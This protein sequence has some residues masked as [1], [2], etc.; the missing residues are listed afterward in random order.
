ME[1]ARAWRYQVTRNALVD[2]LRSSRKHVPLS[3]DLA[4]PADATAPQGD[5]LS[6]CLPRVLAELSEADRLA[7]TLCDTEGHPPLEL[8][9]ET[10]E[11]ACTEAQFPGD[12]RVWLPKRRVVFSGNLVYVDRLLGVLSASGV[13]NGQTASPWMRCNPNAWSQTTAASATWPT[14]NGRLATTTA[15]SPKRSA[16]RRKRRS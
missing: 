12:A 9:G 14:R 11:V 2:W 1:N 6:Q 7:L 8:G 16:R 15:F 3:E 4:A 10:L 13:R 5:G